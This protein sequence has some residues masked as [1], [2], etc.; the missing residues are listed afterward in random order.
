MGLDK[1]TKTPCVFC[2][3]EYYTPDETQQLRKMVTDF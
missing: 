3:V 2:F 1:V